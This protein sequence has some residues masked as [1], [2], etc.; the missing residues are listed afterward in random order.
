MG[1]ITY[2]RT[3]SVN[4]SRDALEEVRQF[5]GSEYG[6]D[7]LPGKP[8]FYRGRRGSQEAHEAIRPTDVTRTPDSL[9]HILD[10]QALKLYDLIWRRFVACQ[11]SAA[12]IERLTVVA[13][14]PEPRD[15]SAHDYA[16]TATASQVLFQGFLKVM[17]L[18]IRRFRD[19]DKEGP[20]NPEEEVDET[21]VDRLPPLAVGDAL[22]VLKWN[23]EGKE[24]KPPAR[25]SEAALVREL[26]ANGVGRPSTYASTIETIVSRKYATR[27]KR[28]L[29]PTDLGMTIVDFLTEKMDELFGVGFTAEMEEELDKIEEQG[30]AWTDML[31]AFYERFLVWLAEAKGPPADVEKVETVLSLF[32]QVEKWA[33]PVKRGN[34]TRDDAR[35]V[36]SIREL[37][38]DENK[39]VS[40]NQFKWL[41]NILLKYRDQVPAAEEAAKSFGFDD[42]VERSANI[43]PPAA[44][45]IRK[46]DLLKN[47]E[48]DKRD[49]DFIDSF[50]SRVQSGSGLSEKQTAVLDRIV[51]AHRAVIPGFE[52]IRHELEIPENIL[53]GAD[54]Q[55]VDP[56]VAPILEALGRIEKWNE[57]APRG[58]GKRVFNDAEFFESISRQFKHKNM[59][60]SRQIAALKRLFVNYK[61]AIPDFEEIAAKYDIRPSERSSMRRSR[62][63]RGQASGTTE[64]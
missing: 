50:N 24:T 27:E 20:E 44:S 11:M 13:A 37:I 33:P 49:L 46:L 3:D 57:P 40:A 25:F 35:F 45:T 41:V 58:K 7:F 18:D 42:L 31:S 9:A 15:A 43:P 5:I 2:M 48:L 34:R 54:R 51:V 38:R 63:G 1:L 28:T 60:T 8:N 6:S 22:D 61:D 29:V 21:I 19:P 32:E 10:P 23:S 59:L 12:R 16:F 4:L 17:A 55:K 36:E 39:T 47:I 62:K 56:A 26:E 53:S 14:A 64:V 52:S 30:L